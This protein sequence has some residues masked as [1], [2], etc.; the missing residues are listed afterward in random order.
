[1]MK[2][3]IAAAVALVL[4]AALPAHADVHVLV[5]AHALRPGELQHLGQ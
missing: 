2:L 1:M 5:H 3:G 4:G